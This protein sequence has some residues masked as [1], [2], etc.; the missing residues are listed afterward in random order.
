MFSSEKTGSRSILCTVRFFFFFFLYQFCYTTHFFS[1]VVSFPG[2]GE[3]IQHMAHFRA[4]RDNRHYTFPGWDK[5][6]K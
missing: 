5:K 1:P 4:I 2:A 3:T 6:K